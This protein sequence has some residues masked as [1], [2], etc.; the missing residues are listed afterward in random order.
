M[1]GISIFQINVD[2]RSH[3]GLNNMMDNDEVSV[4]Q[5]N[6]TPHA[7]LKKRRT[8]RFSL[9]LDNLDMLEKSFADSDALKLERDIL[10]QLGRLGALK[11]FNACL[12]RAPETSNALDLSD[13]LIENIEESKAS[14]KFNDPVGKIIVRTG[15]KE[16]RKS[17]RERAASQNGNKAT[18]VAIQS[19]LRK[20]TFSP[21]KKASSFRRRRLTIA[22]NEAEM[23]KGVKVL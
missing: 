21:A 22:R 7:S 10:M 3:P 5:D 16:E 18:L 12:S 1:C 2:K 23:S 19:D 20:H 6:V 8:L 14:G 13:V 11:F 9:L 15:K 4:Q 17:R